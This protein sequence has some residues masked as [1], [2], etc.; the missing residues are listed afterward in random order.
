M[1]RSAQEYGDC[2]SCLRVNYQNICWKHSLVIQPHQSFTI[3]TIFSQLQLAVP[4]VNRRSPP[5]PPLRTLRAQEEPG[6][7]PAPECSLSATS[8]EQEA[9]EQ[10]TARYKY[11][12][13]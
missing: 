2:S 12:E 13:S 9:E 11:W 5:G 10:Q 1:R 6:G 7:P 8:I 4:D 3:S